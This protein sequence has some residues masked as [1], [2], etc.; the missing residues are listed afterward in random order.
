M[1]FIMNNIF[2]KIDSSHLN[3]V[4]GL[5]EHA[6]H[7][8]NSIWWLIPTVLISL[9]VVKRVYEEVTSS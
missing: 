6:Y 2:S 1:I 7:K 3:C 8:V 4:N 9:Y 5:C